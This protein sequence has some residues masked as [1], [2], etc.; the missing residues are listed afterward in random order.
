MW[1]FWKRYRPFLSAG[2][3]EL[4]TYR[5]N[6]FLYRIGDVM[7]AF[8]AYY[9]WKAV[10]D[11]SKQSLINGF[12]LSD[13][14]FYIIMSFVTTLLTKSDSSFMIGEEVKDGSIIMRLLRP[15]HFAASY[16][17]MEIGFR[18]IVLM[19]VGFPF[20][21]VLSG[22]KVMAGL[23]ILQVLASSCLYLVS[24][25]LAFLINFY[26]NICF[27]FSAFVFKNLWGSNLLK[28]AL[29]AFMSGSLIPLAFFPKM[30]SIVLSFLPF[31]SLV[32]TPVMIVIGKYSLSQ[33]MEALSLQ[34]F[35][36]LVMVVLSQVI[37]KKVQYHLTI[38]GG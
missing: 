32:Y 3:Q 38:Q 30:V 15:V 7:G 29:V 28:N 37:W 10:V 17:F 12:T 23:S 26:F 5:V 4:I 1:S 22:I 25:L 21:V 11:S 31:S 16:L 8:V 19:S 14:T 36:L 33:I 27:G 35:W 9:L 34:I 20:L 18:W 24:L 2:I 6:F 13:M